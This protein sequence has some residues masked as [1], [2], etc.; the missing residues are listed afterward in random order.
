MPRPRKYDYQKDL[1]VTLFIKVPVRILNALEDDLNL[2][3]Y[4][5]SKL[6]EQYLLEYVENNGKKIDTL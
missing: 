1:P 6:V 3:N 2:N 5:I 4:E